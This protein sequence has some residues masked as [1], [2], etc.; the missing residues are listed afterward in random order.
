MRLC[1]WFLL[2][3]TSAA[4][5]GDGTVE[6]HYIASDFPLSADAAAPHWRTVPATIAAN[7]PLG[8]PVPG[9]RT[10]IRTRWTTR[11]LYILFTCPFE[12]LYL[13]DNP[14][15]DRETYGLW[16][17]DVAEFF[18]G[19]DPERIWLYKEFEV[20]PRGE[21][22]DLNINR[23]ELNAKTAWQ[24][25][26]GFQVKTRVD[27]AAKVWYAEMQ[28]PYSALDSRAPAEG[29][30][31]RVNFYRIQG[32]KPD[33]RMIAWQATGARSYHVPEAFGKLK[34]VKRP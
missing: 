7:G 26:S 10:E 16:E 32:P 1:T 4:F 8:E 2:G 3:F 30:E 9:H 11:Y 27:E 25:N 22:V 24:W 15:T 21:W 20:S 13:K 6:S 31:L 28:I 33:R 19:S 18:S 12:Q 34:L 17:W 23:K 14:V 29:R 5:C